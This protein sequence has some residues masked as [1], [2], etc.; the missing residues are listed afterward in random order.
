MILSQARDPADAL[1]IK[2]WLVQDSVFGSVR[3][4]RPSPKNTFTRCR[5]CYSRFPYDL[6]S[7]SAIYSHVDSLPLDKHGVLYC[8]S[9]IRAT[10]IISCLEL[11]WLEACQFEDVIYLRR[12]SYIRPFCN[13]PSTS[14][15]C[16]QVQANSSRCIEEASDLESCPC[17]V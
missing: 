16:F 12:L 3:R 11:H 8:L 7:S 17:K 13:L 2:C 4:A 14:F 15:A 6:R 1:G 5:C 9:P 10:S